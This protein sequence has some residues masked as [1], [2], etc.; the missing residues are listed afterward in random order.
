VSEGAEAKGGTDRETPNMAAGEHAK[1]L[2][3]AVDVQLSEQLRRL[4]D[5]FVEAFDGLEVLGFRGELT[6]V[7]R[8]DQIVDLLRFCRDDDDVRCELLADLSCV[9]WPGGKRVDNAQETTGWPA[10]EV[11]DEVG[12]IEIDYV[13]YSITHNHRFRLRLNVPDEVGTAVPSATAVYASANFMEREAYDFFGVTFDGHP[14]L[15]RIEMPEDWEGHPQRKDYPL[16]GV[17]VQYKGAIIPP[18]D[19]RNY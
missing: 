5:R 14:D 18:P 13:L 3:A 7:A 2:D 17:D 15:R 16:G 9:H 12:R 10:Y 6:L 8:P 4:R 1:Q 19:E 11:G